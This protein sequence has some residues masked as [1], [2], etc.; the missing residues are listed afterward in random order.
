MKGLDGD[1]NILLFSLGNETVEEEEV[2]GFSAFATGGR[3]GSATKSHSCHR[4]RS[5]PH[6]L[7]SPAHMY[8][9]GLSRFYQKYTEAYGLPV[10][11]NY[12]SGRCPFI[13][14]YSAPGKVRL[15]KNG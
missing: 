10:L 15:L 4:V 2:G 8:P 9:S 13:K 6:N 3:P 14:Q 11:G 1:Y 5:V 7:R 12:N